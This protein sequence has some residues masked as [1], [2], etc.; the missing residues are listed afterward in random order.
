MQM[1]N[2]ENRS[3]EEWPV[4]KFANY[5]TNCFL[6]VIPTNKLG[7]VYRVSSSD[8]LWDIQLRSITY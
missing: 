2:G 7:L 5:K 3:T 1:N 4:C 6:E 8:M